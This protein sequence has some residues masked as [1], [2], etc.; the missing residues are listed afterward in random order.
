MN[1]NLSDI[2]QVY[3]SPFTRSKNYLDLD[4]DR[5]PENESVYTG[6]SL[7]VQYNKAHRIVVYC[8]VIVTSRST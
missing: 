1:F 7:F 8:S 4:Q 5:N 2:H 6:H 3:D